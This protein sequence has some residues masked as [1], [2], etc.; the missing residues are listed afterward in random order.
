MLLDPLASFGPFWSASLLAFVA[1]LLVLVVYRVCSSRE[2]FHRA[3]GRIKAHLLELRLFHNDPVLAA[4]AA[5]DCVRANLAYLRLHA[6]PVAILVLPI[7]LIVWE[8]QARLDRR[9]FLAGEPVLLRS[10]WPDSFSAQPEEFPQLVVPKGLEIETPPLRIPVLKE[11]DWR[12]RANRAG[13]YRITLQRDGL[14]GSVDV[15]VSDAL[16]TLSGPAAHGAHKHGSSDPFALWVEHPKS[17]LRLAG[18]HLPW[19]WVILLE[20]FLF[21]FALKGVLGIQL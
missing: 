10:F 21:A 4:R 11:I 8:G 19:S 14:E 1:A 16:A 18:F 7:S 12:L 13:L 5:L 20:T 3:K 15:S 9:P 2:D 6:K 17:D